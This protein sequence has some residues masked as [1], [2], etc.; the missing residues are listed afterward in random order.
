MYEAVVADEALRAK[1]KRWQELAGN[2]HCHFKYTVNPEPAWSP[3]RK[4]LSDARVALVSTGGVHRADQAAFDLENPHGDWS[5]RIIPGDTPT[6]ILR[7]S[8]SHYNHS[9]ADQD[10]NCMFPLDR[11][12]E[13]AE[14][15]YVG[16]VSPVHFGLMGFQPDPTHLLRETAPVVARCLVDAGVDVVVLSPG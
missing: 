1:L 15:G 9:D 11:L 8:H 13:L 12:R 3:L 16:A 14:Q 4:P 7:F 10:P 2:V 5:Y 6:R